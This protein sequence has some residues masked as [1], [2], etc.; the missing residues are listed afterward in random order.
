ME[1]ERSAPIRMRRL[2]S[3]ATCRQQI[4]HLAPVRARHMAELLA[5]ALE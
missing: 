1:R 4:N 5:D 3:G 2:P